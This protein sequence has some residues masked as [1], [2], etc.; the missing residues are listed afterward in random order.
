MPASFRRSRIERCDAPLITWHRAV[1]TESVHLGIPRVLRYTALD[2]VA[3]RTIAERKGGEV[4]PIAFS[5]FWKK[6][7][8]IYRGQ[9][10]ERNPIS[11]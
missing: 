5:K 4:E 9:R 10:A 7:P 11:S 3:Y 2:K 6:Q 1:V 8:S